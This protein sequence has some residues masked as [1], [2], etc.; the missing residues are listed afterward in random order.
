LALFHATIPSA[1]ESG[2]HANEERM[3]KCKRTDWR[4][5]PSPSLMENFSLIERALVWL[6]IPACFIAG[7]LLAD[8]V[9]LVQTAS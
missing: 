1:S 7:Y 3:R 5:S 4:K 9:L 6:F 8:L 2:R